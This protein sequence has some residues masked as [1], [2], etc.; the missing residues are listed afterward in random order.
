[1]PVI[2]GDNGYNVTIFDPSYAGYEQVP[3]LS[4]YDDHP[5]FNCY[6]TYGMFSIFDDDKNSEASLKAS[7]RVNEIRNRNFF[8]FSLMKISPLVIQETIYDDGGYNESVSVSDNSAGDLNV[9]PIQH[10]YGLSKSTGLSNTFLNS[11]PVLTKLTD[12]TDVNDSS[13]NTFF[14]MSNI[15]THSPNLLQE[16]DY[17]PALSVDNTAYDTEDLV[18]RYTLNGVTMK[19]ENADQVTHYHV[20]MA[21]LL[22]LGEWFDYLREQGVYDNT[23]III[24]SDH[25]RDLD[26]FDIDCEGKNME[27]FLPLLMVK[28]FDSKGFTICE[29][30]MTNGDT[31]VLATSGIIDD[32][33]NPAT[34][35]PINSDAKTGPQTVFYSPIA[36]I[37]VNNGNTFLP[38]SWYTFTGGDPHDPDNW[39]YLGDY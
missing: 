7:E 37:S 1:M 15:A 26:Q 20:N 19:M 24:V 4:I 17:V 21:A 5:E 28:D 27:H 10:M 2:F 11:Y 39:T 12:L 35:K 33:V 23:R 29:D 38:G 3:D 30:L 34:G 18:T 6:V 31:P 36:M 25:G 14:I 13:E 9:S 32:P 8:F 16:P 22:R